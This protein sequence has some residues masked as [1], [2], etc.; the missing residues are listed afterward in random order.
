MKAIEIFGSQRIATSLDERKLLKKLPI[1]FENLSDRER[2]VAYD[3]YKK[4]VVL[5]SDDG[6][7]ELNKLS[8]IADIEW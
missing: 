1:N 3:L 6:D 8:N 4:T 2:Q 7:I 5:I